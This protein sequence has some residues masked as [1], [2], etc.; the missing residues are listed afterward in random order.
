LF[1]S[2]NLFFIYYSFFLIAALAANAVH[3]AAA[4]G[5]QFP[6]ANF[7]LTG[8]LVIFAVIAVVN[9]LAV[10]VAPVEFRALKDYSPANFTAPY[11]LTHDRPLWQNPNRP[12]RRRLSRSEYLTAPRFPA[13]SSAKSH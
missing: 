6:A 10:T 5:A 3:D 11:H 1:K 8:T 7:A 9:K 12:A 2:D 13:L 4:T